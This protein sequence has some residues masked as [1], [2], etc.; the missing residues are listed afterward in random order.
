MESEIEKNLQI[1]EGRKNYLTKLKSRLILVIPMFILSIM[2]IVIGV[3]FIPKSSQ[4]IDLTFSFN[5]SNVS[6]QVSRTDVGAKTSESVSSLTFSPEV[7]PLQVEIDSWSNSIEFD[8]NQ[9]DITLSI[10]VVNTTSSPIRFKIQNL[11]KKVDNLN[12]NLSSEEGVEI[13]SLQTGV[14]SITL[15]AINKNVQVKSSQLDFQIS[16]EKI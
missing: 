6:A 16:L 13:Q 4:K 7:S 1:Q 8:D 12:V 10:K 15:S 11:S 9:G 14:V 2:F 5:S 3:L